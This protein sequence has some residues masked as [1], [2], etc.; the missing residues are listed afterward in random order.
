MRDRDLILGVLASQAGFVTPAQVM[1]AAASRLMNEDGPSLLTQLERTGALSQVRRTLLE[2]IAN[3]ALAARNGDATEVLRTLGGEAAVSRTFG[4]GGPSDAGRGTRDRDDRPI[5]PER[6]G[7]YARLE[8]LGRGAQSVVL[9]AMDEFVGREV[10]LKELKDSID[11][12]TSS[13]TPAV[14]RARFLREVR[15]TAQLDHPGIV[16]IHELAQ[17][18]DG[19][20]FSAQKL[21][22]GRTL[23]A[24]LTHCESLAQRLELLPHLIDVCQALAYAHSQGVIHRDVKPSNI[25]VGDFGET[26][27]VDWGLAKRRGEQES[28]GGGSAISA[29]PFRTL[30]GQALGT[31]AYMSPEQARGAVGEIDERSDVFGLGAILYEI[32][33]GRVPFEASTAE[34]AVQ[35]V[36]AGRLVPVRSLSPEAPPELVAI[37]ERALHRDPLA[38]YQSADGLARDLLAFRSGH[39]V[40]AYEYG[41]WELVRKFVARNR[42]LSAVSVV[43]LGV[44]LVSAATIA[45]QLYGARLNLAASFLERARAAEQKAD[46]GKA[47]GYYAASRLH[48]DSQEARWGSALARERIPRR[49][50]AKS[51]VDRSYLDVGYD[52]DGRGIVLAIET[53]QVIA[54]DLLSGQERWRYQA[55]ERFSDANLLGDGLVRISEPGHLL[56]LD[57]ITGGL[58]DNFDLTEPHPCQWGPPIRQVLVGNGTLVTSGPDG[59]KRW[60]K[61]GVRPVCAASPDGKR[62]AFR[63]LDGLIHLWD[64]EGKKE[65]ATRPA[66]DVSQLFF[67]AHGLAAVR[68]RSVQLFGGPEG[69]FSIVLPGRGNSPTETPTPSANAV[70]PDGHWLVVSPISSSEADL[71]DL[72]SRSVVSSVSFAAGVPRFAFSPA[73]D[74]LFVAGLGNGTSLAA[75]EVA[76]PSTSRAFQGTPLMIVYASQDARRILLNL[77]DPL[78]PRFELRDQSGT[79][80][81]TGGVGRPG[82]AAFLSA[83]GRRIAVSSDHGARVLDAETGRELAQVDCQKCFRLG[84][85]ADGSRLLTGSETRLAIW[86]V[87]SAKMVWSETE[88][89]GRLSGP[90]HLSGDGRSVLWGKDRTLYVHH[91][92]ASPDTELQLDQR[93]M[94][95]AFSYD[96]TRLAAVT[97]GT[98]GV[99]D[100]GTLAP[101]WQVRNPSWGPQFVLWSGDDSVVMVHYVAQGVAL[102]ESATGGRFATIP[103]NKPGALGGHEQV[104][105]DLRHRISRGNSIWELAP[106]PRPDDGPP[107]E[108][109]ERVLTEAGLQ[110]QGIEL[111]DAPPSPSGGPQ[112]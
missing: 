69:D 73:G 63:D 24:R 59:E 100:S 109:L 72:R 83:D 57:G 53:G 111:V 16:Q 84:L 78:D 38:R 75:W 89:L 4:T 77:G 12:D 49:L 74:Q 103:V 20:L 112:R 82:L 13:P 96:G 44:L 62:V 48:H 67:T 21:I 51:S 11:P 29:D 33:T 31:P 55:G 95:A 79:V 64:V 36:L 23:K 94:S 8:E 80:L 108:S 81:L 40:G 34:Q 92:G 42:G 47:A 104:L 99:W 18:P 52:R 91:E 6:I 88:R 106:L 43:A 26:V 7:Q 5:P 93:V 27:L 71:I 2:A 22:R 85:S 15:L 56:Y 50:F 39:R 98:V 102:H 35:N 101:R 1:E 19:T 41:S 76:V 105:P 54:R 68:S 97:A 107:R 110:M 28:S 66:P 9:R 30:T 61:V 10:A 65:V 87:T 37:A 25:M 58:I 45:W 60:W 17:R 70:S 32:L 86:D 3:E 14:A 90:L 46:W